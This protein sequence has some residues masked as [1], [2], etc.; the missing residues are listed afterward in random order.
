MFNKPKAIN[1]QQSQKLLL[2]PEVVYILGH[3]LLQQ[4]LSV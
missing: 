1:S 4:R 3:T 2:I